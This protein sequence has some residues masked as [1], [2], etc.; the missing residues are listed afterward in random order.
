M[1]H[2]CN[3]YVFSAVYQVHSDICIS[4][5]IKRGK[6]SVRSFVRTSVTVGVAPMTSSWE[7]G[8]QWQ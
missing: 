2:C 6:V 1:H 4:L 5:Y 7:W 8:L 3:L